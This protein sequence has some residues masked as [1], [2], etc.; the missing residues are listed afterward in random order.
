[1][2]FRVNDIYSYDDLMKPVLD[3]YKSNLSDPDSVLLRNVLQHN[4][5]MSDDTYTFDREY[6]LSSSYYLQVADIQINK[7]RKTFFQTYDFLAMNKKVAFCI[8]LLALLLFVMTSVQSNFFMVLFASFFL[9]FFNFSIFKIVNALMQSDANMPIYLSFGVLAI[10]ALVCT[11]SIL[12]SKSK[13]AIVST[14]LLIQMVSLLGI[15]LL[16]FKEDD[17][18]RNFNY[19]AFYIGLLFVLTLFYRKYLSLPVRR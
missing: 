15:F 7:I 8:G 6:L 13:K 9:V 17:I 18:I 4:G 14:L 3:C 5:F 2:N 12:F 16:I 19:L 11:W 1:M 10:F